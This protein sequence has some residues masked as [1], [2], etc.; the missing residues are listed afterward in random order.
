M[1]I[2]NDAQEKLERRYAMKQSGIGIHTVEK[3]VAELFAL[4][5]D[6]L[7]GQGSAGGLRR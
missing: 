1:T 7:Y 5:T 4:K 6:D 2:P 3:R